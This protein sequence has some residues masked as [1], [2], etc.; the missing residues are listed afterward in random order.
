MADFR[1]RHCLPLIGEIRDL[2]ILANLAGMV[3]RVADRA[4]QAAIDLA[5]AADVTI[6]DAANDSPASSNLTRRSLADKFITAME[7]NNDYSRS[8]IQKY[9]GTMRTLCAILGDAADPEKVSDT[10]Y[11]GLPGPNV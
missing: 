1:D 6:A 4:T 3:L 10:E 5:A 9:T 2:D 7:A 11:Q 8:T